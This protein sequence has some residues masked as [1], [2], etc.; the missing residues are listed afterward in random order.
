MF[1]FSILIFHREAYSAKRLI[2]R[3]IIFSGKTGRVLRWSEVPDEKE[4]YFSPVLYTLKNG[5]ELIVFGTGGET[6]PGGLYVI[7][8]MDFYYGKIKNAKSLYQDRYKGE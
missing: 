8:L 6:H 3:L 7:P 5:T 1:F 2:G 4:T